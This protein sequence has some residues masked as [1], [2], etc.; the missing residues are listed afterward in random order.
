[1]T[2]KRIVLA[3]MITGVLAISATLLSAQSSEGASGAEQVVDRAASQGE[4]FDIFDRWREAQAQ[5]LEGTWILTV[6]P[7]SS[8]RR[9][10]APTRPSRMFVST[11]IL[12]FIKLVACRIGRAA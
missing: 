9:P 12:S 5:R 7:A 1:M 2:A 11:R 6:S 10:S 3:L 8:H 4:L